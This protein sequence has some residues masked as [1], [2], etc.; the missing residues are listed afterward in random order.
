MEVQEQ[1][2]EKLIAF[3]ADFLSDAELLAII[4]RTGY[5]GK[6]VLQWSAELLDRYG[7]WA[8]LA[9]LN[10][11]DLC[12]KE[13][14]IG[15]GPA[16]TAEL[17]AVLE[18]GKRI[19]YSQPQKLSIRTPQDVEELLLPLLRDE[20]QEKFFLLSLDIKSCLIRYDVVFIGT[21]DQALVHPR[22]V[23]ARALKRGAARIIVA[24]N[25]PS[26]DPMPS[27][28]DELVTRRLRD[29]GKLIGIELVDHIIIGNGR[30]VSLREMGV[31]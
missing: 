25:H 13:G 19:A 15:F 2:R 23:Y 17:M 29:A 6:N 22:E 1:P 24:H 26:G 4:L 31:F 10:S 20:K 18:I 16:K 14:E 27:Y 9:Q 28:D 3:G 21:I 5:K 11:E 30:S 7:G 8:G 12:G